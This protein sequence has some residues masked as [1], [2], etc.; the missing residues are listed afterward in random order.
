MDALR[1]WITGIAVVA[2]LETVVLALVPAGSG[3]KTVQLCLSLLLLLVVLG[4]LLGGQL[5]PDADGL[6]GGYRE[7]N[8][9]KT[10]QDLMSDIIAGQSAAYIVSEAAALGLDIEADISCVVTDYY[11]QP[12]QI[13]VRALVPAFARSALSGRIEAEL[14][15]PPE[16]QSYREKSK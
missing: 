11:P 14:G 6:L 2:M 4:P 15:I 9:A 8:F 7:E 13:T 16:R 1:Q 5:L 12:Y 10:G 3:K